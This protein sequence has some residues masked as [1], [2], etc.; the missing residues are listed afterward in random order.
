MTFKC[1]INKT[2]QNKNKK[3]KKLKICPNL[4]FQLMGFKD[5]TRA[6]FYHAALNEEI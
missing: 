5:F 3:S 2:K 1:F 4:S 6:Q